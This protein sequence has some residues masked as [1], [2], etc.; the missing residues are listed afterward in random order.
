M[1]IRHFYN[2]CDYVT[3]S[4][5]HRIFTFLQPDV[6]SVYKVQQQL[7]SSLCQ[8]VYWTYQEKLRAKELVNDW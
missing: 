3:L 1:I 2:E 7:H 8:T 4:G 5:E 6:M